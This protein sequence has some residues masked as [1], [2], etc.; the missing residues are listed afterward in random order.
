MIREAIKSHNEKHKDE[1]KSLAH[2]ARVLEKNGLM[3]FQSAL[4]MFHLI[5]NNKQGKIGF[6]AAEIIA[7]ELSMTINELFGLRTSK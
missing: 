6:D 5:D 1:P 3:T 4:N 7:D 2:L